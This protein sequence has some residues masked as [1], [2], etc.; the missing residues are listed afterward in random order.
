M[1]PAA[2]SIVRVVVMSI[3]LAGCSDVTAPLVARPFD[4]LLQPGL[5][6]ASTVTGAAGQEVI[7]VTV[8]LSNPDLAPR[9]Y[10]ERAPCV[11]LIRLYATPAR[12][13][14]PVYADEW[15]PGGCKSIPLVVTL[16]SHAS[17]SLVR[18][19]HPGLIAGSPPSLQLL[20]AGRYYASVNIGVQELVAG[21]TEM[22]AGELVIAQ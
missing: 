19:S 13:G 6:V 8:T 1:P 14:V 21:T 3:L 20:P 10:T 18:A 22:P 12:S 2:S 17:A 7:E 9:T 16:A 5:A 15:M 4:D 11:L